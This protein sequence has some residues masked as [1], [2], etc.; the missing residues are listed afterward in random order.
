MGGIIYS[1]YVKENETK[2]LPKVITVPEIKKIIEVE[3]TNEGI[4]LNLPNKAY[5]DN[6]DQIHFERYIKKD[7]E[8]ILYQKMWIKNN[9]ITNIKSITDYF[10]E[11]DKEYFYSFAYFDHSTLDTIK[12]DKVGITA[13]G[14]KGE[15]LLK[16]KQKVTYDEKTG[17]MTFPSGIQ[18]NKKITS[19]YNRVSFTVQYYN[20][21]TMYSNYLRYNF[22]ETGRKKQKINFPET[23][24]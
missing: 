9:K 23:A 21:D 10:V 11:K 24:N 22:E 15:L 12:T 20:N 7:E 3:A 5:N 1:L 14:G 2:G 16:I 18:S 4:K 8:Y 13:K 17:I 19:G 6:I